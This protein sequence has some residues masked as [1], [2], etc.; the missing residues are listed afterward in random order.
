MQVLVRED[1]H[2]DLPTLQAQLLLY[3]VHVELWEV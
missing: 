1:H 3:G 2:F